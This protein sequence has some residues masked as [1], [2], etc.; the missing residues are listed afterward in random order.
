MRSV[1]KVDHA[2]I[3][4]GVVFGVISIGVFVLYAIVAWDSAT[5]I[6]FQSRFLPM[7][8]LCIAMSIVRRPIERLSRR[9]RFLAW[10]L[11]GTV[12]AALFTFS[13]G[14]PMNPAVAA[15]MGLALAIIDL[16]T[17]HFHR[18]RDAEHG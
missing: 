7:I 4:F 3:L 17:E 2:D 13:W 15:G 16:V 5:S 1:R 11:F 14:D 18:K 6:S 10:F 9:P 12:S 8:G